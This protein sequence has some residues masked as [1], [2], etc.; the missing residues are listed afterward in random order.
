LKSGRSFTHNSGPRRDRST[1]R[2]PH[3]RAVDTIHLGR[4]LDV[5]VLFEDKWIL[6]VNK[7]AGLLVCQESWERTRRNL[8]HLLQS[9]IDHRAYWAVH[10][11]LRYLKNVHRLD[12]PTTGV[13]LLAKSRFAL[14]SLS[15]LFRLRHIQKTYYALVT[16]NPPPKPFDISS[17]IAPHPRITGLMVIDA[18]RGKPAD[19]HVEVVAKEGPLSLLKVSPRSGRTHQIR[20]HLASM[21]LPLVGDSQYGKA[22]TSER[23]MLHAA[24]LNFVHPFTKRP[25]VIRAPL[26]RDFKIQTSVGTGT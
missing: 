1:E 11:G 5:E 10:R 12:A 22:K 3:R 24:E 8:M 6:A 15:E 19:T 17:P 25:V 23:L 13:L 2:S 20:I 14:M 9:G 18:K 16:G 21:G 7:P 26:P 4:N